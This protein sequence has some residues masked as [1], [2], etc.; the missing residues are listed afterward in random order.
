ML[1]AVFYV[2]RTGCQWRALPRD[3]RRWCSVWSTFRRW[4]ED[5]TLAMMY[6]ALHAQWRKQAGRKAD[7]TAAI[8]D[9][10]IVKTSEK[11]GFLD[12]KAARGS[13]GANATS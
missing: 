10:Q 9:S 13:R 2:V 6:D 3:F 8:V 5:G 1:D 11:G 4:R 12:T 7:P